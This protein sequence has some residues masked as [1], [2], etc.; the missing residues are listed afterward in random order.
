MPDAITAAIIAALVGGAAGFRIAF[1]YLRAKDLPA[2]PGKGLS[3]RT[4]EAGHWGRYSVLG[5]GGKLFV[6]DDRLHETTPAES[7]DDALDLMNEL[8][9]KHD[10]SAYSWEPCSVARRLEEDEWDRK[11][12]G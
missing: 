11:R 6:H 7:L 8:N 4:G 9:G 3:V 5:A 2:H 1:A 10:R 12:R